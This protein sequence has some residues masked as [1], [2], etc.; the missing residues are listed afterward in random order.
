MTPHHVVATAGHVDH[1]KSTLVRALT[2]QEPDRWAEE[3][4][5]GLT[6]DLGFVWTDL[7]TAGTVAFVDVPGHHRFVDNA[8]AGAGAVEDVLLVVAADDGWSAQTEEHVEIADLLGLRGIAVAITKVAVVDAARVADVTADVRARLAGTSLAG[9]PLV[10][11]DGP[12]GVGV[13]DLVDVL[14]ERLADAAT[15][16]LVGRARLWIDRAFTVRGTGTVVT[17]TLAGGPLRVGDEVAVHGTG[18]TSRVRGLQSLGSGVEAATGP[19]RVAVALSDIGV[20]DLGRGDAVVSPPDRWLPTTRVDLTAQALP[21]RELDRVGDWVVHVGSARLPVE[22]VPIDGAVTTDGGPLRLEVPRPLPLLH[23]DRL[24]LR[25]TGRRAT[26]GGGRVLDPHPSAR[27]PR[28]DERRAFVSRLARLATGDDV[29]AGLVAGGARPSARV[30]A[31]LRNGATPTA[32]TVVAGMV[33]DADLV[34]DVVPAVLA[35]ATTASPVTALVAAAEDVPLERSAV[36]AVIRGLVDDGRLR[37][38]PEGLVAADAADDVTAAHDERVAAFLAALDDAGLSPPAVDEVTAA[39][40]VTRAEVQQ[41]EQR[42]EVVRAGKLLFHARRVE[43]AVAVVRRLG[44]GG[45]FT[46]SQARA[47]WDTTRR[48]AIPLLELLDARRITTFDGQTRTL[49][50]ER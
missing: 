16:P 40:G 3:R 32:A 44:A 26:M 41:L 10:Q 47:A 25:E 8:L 39:T 24:V 7:P 21:G 34:R 6:I 17:G 2:G 42:G 13:T 27:L 11:V 28:G 19:A 9:A 29:V 43:E 45:P 30:A 37:A 4:R 38:T 15:T 31:A 36:E 49:T 33:A 12:A 14:D 35:A 1:G 23:G 22:V 5:R 46:A 50:P 18:R 20:D 48:S